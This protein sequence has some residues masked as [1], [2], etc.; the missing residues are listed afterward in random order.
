MDEVAYAEVARAESPRGEVVLRE[1]RRDG[2][3]SVTELRVNGTYVMDT[4]ETGSERA[5]AALALEQVAD[6]RSV[7]VGGLGLGFTAR[8]VLSDVRVERLVVVEIEEAL[9]GWLRDGTIP[10]GRE[11]LADRRLNV[12]ESDIA[13][14]VEEAGSGTTYDLV[15][16]D[17]DNGPDQLVHLENAA[18]Y[19][20]PFLSRLRDLLTPDGVVAVWSAHRAPALE[21]TMDR[22][23]GSC[24]RIPHAVRLGEREEE[25]TLY[26]APAR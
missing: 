11:L 17:V 21:A 20:E 6:P 16:L 5:L 4:L 8:E 9:V 18:V 15:L 24:R 19:Q 7:L 23:F 26:L 13:T 14:A 12:V 22:V 10:G 1:R 3:P 2:A 25:Y